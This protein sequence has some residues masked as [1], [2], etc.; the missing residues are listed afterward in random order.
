MAKRSK[1]RPVARG[2]ALHEEK[3]KG[4]PIWVRAPVRGCEHFSQLKRGLLYKLAKDG[5]IRTTSTR[6]PG[7]IKGTRLFHL[8]SIIS[9]LDQQERKGA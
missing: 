6:Q 2:T 7:Q 5:F 9:Y 4:L 3:K 8:G 1:E